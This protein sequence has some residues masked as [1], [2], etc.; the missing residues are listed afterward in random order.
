V[1]WVV[2]AV[3]LLAGYG[4]AWLD[5]FWAASREQSACFEPLQPADRS[6]AL[7]ADPDGKLAAV[8]GAVALAALV[9]ALAFSP[10]TRP[11]RRRCGVSRA[12]SCGW[13]SSWD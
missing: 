5:R 13:R 11:G 2:L 7:L 12:R 4:I 6:T 10:A 3:A 8:Y 9:L 1:V